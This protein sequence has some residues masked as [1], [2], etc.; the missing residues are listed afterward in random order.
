MEKKS[1]RGGDKK[2]KKKSRTKKD[3]TV[4]RN[5]IKAMHLQ[6]H[7][8]TLSALHKR[9]RKAYKRLL[10]KCLRFR[11]KL[12]G[13]TP[14]NRV[15]FSWPA[16]PD[17]FHAVARY[18]SCFV[19]ATLEHGAVYNRPNEK[20]ATPL[21]AYYWRDV[22]GEHYYTL[23]D[24]VARKDVHIKLLVFKEGVQSIED[25]LALL[26]KTRR[27]VQKALSKPE[28]KK[29]KRSKERRRRE[30]SDSDMENSSFM[31]SGD[32]EDWGSDD[33]TEY[34]PS[35][36][37]DDDDD[38]DDSEDDEGSDSTSDDEDDLSDGCVSGDEEEESSGDDDD[39]DSEISTR[40]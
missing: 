39:D 16:K 9:D 31:E 24:Y 38:D 36:G 34:V 13:R 22:S 18:E 4:A 11:T 20:V 40:Y 23:V 10:R 17:V 32:D 37:D 29:R 3:E 15:F 35:G 26:S 30:E 2:D 14:G 7:R 8:E 33:D 12:D 19:G 6:C 21:A 27:S 1:K 28:E 25:A 5:V